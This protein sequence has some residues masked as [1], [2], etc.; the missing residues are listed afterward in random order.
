MER[1]KEI[2]QWVAV[3]AVSMGVLISLWLALWIGYILGFDM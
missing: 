2:L 3:A 1:V